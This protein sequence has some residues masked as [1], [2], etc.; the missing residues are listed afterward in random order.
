MSLYWFLH[1]KVVIPAQ[2]FDKNS[3]QRGERLG[4]L[5][6]PIFYGSTVFINIYALLHHQED[7]GFL[8]DIPY[9]SKWILS[10]YKFH[11]NIYNLYILSYLLLR[12]YLYPDFSGPCDFSCS[13]CSILFCPIFQ[14]RMVSNFRRKNWALSQKIRTLTFWT[15]RL[16]VQYPWKMQKRK[17][18]R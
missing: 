16:R 9:N 12:L 10:K 6:L 17:I 11:L 3:N 1:V 18:Y 4:L 7:G 2:D 5:L 13:F 15:L 8:Q 14:E